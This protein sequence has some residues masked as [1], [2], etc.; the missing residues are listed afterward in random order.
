MISAGIRYTLSVIL[1]VSVTA[2]RLSAQEIPEGEIKSVRLHREEWNLSYPII[3]LDSDEKLI[4]HFDLLGESIETYYYSFI[5]CDKDW[6]PSQVFESEY[7]DGF[8]ENQVQ[9]YKMS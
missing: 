6:D 1:L 5:H 9:D 4:L 2:G 3:R 8:V 7:L